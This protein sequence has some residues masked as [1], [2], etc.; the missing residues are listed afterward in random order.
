MVGNIFRAIAQLTLGKLSTPAYDPY[1]GMPAG[2]RSAVAFRFNAKDDANFVLRMDGAYYYV[3]SYTDPISLITV[4]Q[5][6]DS[7]QFM[8]ERDRVIAVGGNLT[9]LKSV[10]SVVHEE[11]WVVFSDMDLRGGSTNLYGSSMSCSFVSLDFDPVWRPWGI[12]YRV[13]NVPTNI[14]SLYTKQ[15]TSCEGVRGGVSQIINIGDQVL[16]GTGVGMTGAYYDVI[17][18][19]RVLTSGERSDLQTYLQEFHSFNP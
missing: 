4:S 8:R 1:Y 12:N 18:F 6:V 15:T 16:P 2:L 19:N 10:I 13:N 14:F 17:V 5:D 3:V 11:V 7:R 9:S